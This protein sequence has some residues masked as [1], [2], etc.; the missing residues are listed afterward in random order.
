MDG[1]MILFRWRSYRLRKAIEPLQAAFFF[2]AVESDRKI[3]FVNRAAKKHRR[4]SKN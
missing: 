1:A 2:D 3:N 4:R